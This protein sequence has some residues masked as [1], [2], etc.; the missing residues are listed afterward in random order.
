VEGLTLRRLRAG[1]EAA[2]AALLAAAP[3]AAPWSA[4]SCA[5]FAAA[6]HGW[7][8]RQGGEAAGFI[9]ARVAADECEILNLAVARAYRRRG[10]ARR[11][12]EHALAEARRAGARRCWLE[13][14]ASNAGAIA[15]YRALG[16][17]RS[18]LRRGYYSA[19]VEDAVVMS[20][21]MQ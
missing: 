19:P 5:S 3:E 7:L 10:V 16:F 21:E 17:R 15:C 9:A 1:D 18:G 12:V 14:R 8:A 13:V 20:R 11:L 6:G 2:V 4:E